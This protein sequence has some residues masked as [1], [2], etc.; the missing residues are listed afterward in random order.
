MK[1]S[2]WYMAIGFVI[3]CLA[4]AWSLV[5]EGSMTGPELLLNVVAFI[6]GLALLGFGFYRSRNPSEAMRRRD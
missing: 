3:F 5:P 6:I 4:L 2:D 1:E